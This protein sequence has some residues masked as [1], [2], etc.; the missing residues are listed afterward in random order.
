MTVGTDIRSLPLKQ[1]G[2][3]RGELPHDWAERDSLACYLL[4]IADAKARV[5][6]GEP[7]PAWLYQAPKGGV[8]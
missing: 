8:E 7:L 4:G 1:D 3:G 5:D 2:D 6:A